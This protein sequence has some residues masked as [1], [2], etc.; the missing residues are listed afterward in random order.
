MSASSLETGGTQPSHPNR[1][2]VGTIQARADLADFLS[3]CN[4][5][6]KK[7]IDEEYARFRQP[8]VNYAT[9]KPCHSRAGVR[10]SMARFLDGRGSNHQKGP[11][12]FE[13]TGFSLGNLGKDVSHVLNFID[14]LV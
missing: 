4:R 14:T 2:S 6:I 13:M 8:E 11:E 1:L 12:V 10:N 5:T 9:S 7:P 3:R